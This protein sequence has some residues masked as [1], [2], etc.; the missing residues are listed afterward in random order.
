MIGIINVTAFIIITFTVFFLLAEM[1][2]AHVFNVIN[3]SL[4]KR[5][6]RRREYEEQKAIEK[7]LR[8]GQSIFFKVDLALIKSGIQRKIPFFTTEI[9]I[10]CMTLTAFVLFI[11]CTV[12]GAA[13]VISVIISVSGTALWLFII[14]ILLN[15]NNEKIEK[16]LMKFVNLIENYSRIYDDIREI[17]KYSAPFLDEPL[18]SAVNECVMELDLKSDT[19]AAFK[20]LE[21]KVGH[22]QFGELVRNLELCSRHNTDYAAVIRKNREIIQDYIAERQTRKQMA[23]QARINII[24]LYAG[25]VIAFKMLAKIGDTKL[26]TLLVSSVTGNFVIMMCSAVII[27]S[28]Y[29][30]VKMTD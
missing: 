4:K 16:N 27:F 26:T 5:A 10:I 12:L 25:A 20:K 2:K 11:T 13:P 7:G 23:A 30:M 14:K 1:K 22:R 28:I 3:D 6:A 15:Y 18:K 9:L 17:F 24:I 8:E 29:K 21:I 19:Y